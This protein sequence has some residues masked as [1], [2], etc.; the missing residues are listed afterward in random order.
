MTPLSISRNDSISLAVLLPY[1]KRD[2]ITGDWRRLRRE[3]LHDFCSSPHTIRMIRSR[4]MRCAEQVAREREWEKGQVHTGYWLEKL[5]ER[6]HLEI[7]GREG[8]IILKSSFKK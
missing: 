5:R 7:R 2:E 3:K 1:Y 4:R 8:R 6:V